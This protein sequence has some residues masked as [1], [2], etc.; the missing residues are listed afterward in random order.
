M[1]QIKSLSSKL[2]EG[3]A[4]REGAMLAA[5]T[6][7]RHEAVTCCYGLISDAQAQMLELDLLDEKFGQLLVKGP[8]MD[9]SHVCVYFDW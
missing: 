2:H 1:K 4:E 3:V 7:R 9:I 5:C 8:I 6:R